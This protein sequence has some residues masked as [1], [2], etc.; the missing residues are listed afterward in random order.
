MLLHYREAGTGLPMV[1][2]HG[3]G[4]DSTYFKHQIAYFSKKFRVIAVDTRGHGE[5]PRGTGPFHLKRFADDLKDLLDFLSIKEVILLGFSDGGNIGILF[6]VKYPSYVKLLIL[7][8]ANLDPFGVKPMV[9]LSVIKDYCK[10]LKAGDR[11]QEEILGLMIKE[12]RLRPE[13]LKKIQAPALVI[14]GDRDMIRDSHSRL[15][16]RSLPN[17]TFC[18]IR[19]SHFA[20]AE[21]PEAFNRAVEE[22]LAEHLRI[23]ADSEPELIHE[24]REKWRHRQP[25]IL[26]KHQTRCSSVLVPLVQVE[27][28][29]EVLFQVRAS[30]LLRQPG[31]VCFPGGAVEASETC[32]EAAVRETMEELLIRRDQIEVLA[33]LDYMETSGG[34]I[35]KAYLGLIKDYRGTFSEDEVDHVFTVP[36]SWFLDHDPER[37]TAAVHTIPD[38]DFPFDRVPG[39]RDYPWRKGR[40]DVYFYQYDRET[41]WGMTAKIL[42]GFIKLYRG[43]RL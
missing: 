25:E 22:F 41:I 5:S 23:S 18:R 34:S 16:A 31:E 10:A 39:G 30:S 43:E 36:L 26:E 32:E 1:L 14:V 8:G 20:A 7:N 9:G 21:E 11:K 4:E 29:I 19:G 35:V 24:M 33:P 42:F 38:E 13:H 2:L 28:R 40:Y 27:D 12:P 17:G 37:Y 3:N 6:S 15:I